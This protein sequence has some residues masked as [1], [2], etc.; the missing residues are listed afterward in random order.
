[1][2][3]ED[4]CFTWEHLIQNDNILRYQNKAKSEYVFICSDFNLYILE[5][6]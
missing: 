6:N 1:M 3:T 2:Y 5:N 4:L